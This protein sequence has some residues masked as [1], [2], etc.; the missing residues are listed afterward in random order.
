MKIL[1]ISGHGAGDPGAVSPLGGEAV[2]TVVMVQKIQK[3]LE[4][5]ATVEL[6]PV[7]RNAYSDINNGCLKVNFSNYDYMLEVHF[8]ACVNDI[9]GNGVTTGT[10]IYVTSSEKGITVEQAIVAK[11]AALG[12]KNRG[13]KRTNFTVI[14]KC[15]IPEYQRHFW[16]RVSLTTPTT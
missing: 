16:K 10:E 14:N 4:G 11:I 8:N 1:L 7:E 2:E 15:K 13:V 3:A 9:N 5:F 12:L 6:Y